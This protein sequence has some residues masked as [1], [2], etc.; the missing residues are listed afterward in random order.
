[1]EQFDGGTGA[2]EFVV[3]T[4]AHDRGRAVFREG[5]TD[6]AAEAADDIV[7]FCRHD[8]AAITGR[9]DDALLIEGFYGVDVDD[10]GGNA[11]I[12]QL[13]RS[14]QRFVDHE[15]GGHDGNVV[16][17]GQDLGLAP[18]ELV[19]AVEDDRDGE[20]PES[21]VDRTVILRGGD[22]RSL[23][24]DG[25]GRVDD[26]HAGDGAHEGDV[27]VALVGCAVFTDGDTGM[28]GAELD[29]QVRIAD[30][31]ADLLEGTTRREHGKGAREDGEAG[32]AQAGRDADHVL[33]GD[34]AVEEAVG[35]FLL[36]LGGLGGAGEVGVKDH[37]FLI[38][39][40]EVQK[41][42]CVTDAGCFGDD[43]CHGSSLLIPVPPGSRA[44]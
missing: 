24:F 13:F 44:R 30:R 36:E 14:H 37:D 31:V 40:T 5:L 32:K 25:I 29:V 39:L 33:L 23:G 10:A 27:L 4:D 11:V 20:A 1:M 34:T 9:V 19:V 43:I 26:G 7:L 22:G 3:D 41:A 16:A 35:V 15:A 8:T 38:G 28:G 6:R 42:F 21:H 18:L 17:F 2:A 12:L